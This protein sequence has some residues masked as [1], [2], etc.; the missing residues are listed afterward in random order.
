MKNGKLS[1]ILYRPCQTPRQSRL[2]GPVE[3]SKPLARCV[4]VG[5]AFVAVMALGVAIFLPNT[6]CLEQ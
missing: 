4:V 6:W 2:P 3:S 1:W 5:G